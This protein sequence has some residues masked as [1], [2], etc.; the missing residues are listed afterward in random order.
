MF[1]RIYV[2]AETDQRLRMLK[3]RTRLAPNILCRIG[4]CLSISEPGVPDGDL[5]GTTQAREF[6]RYTLTGA[7]DELFFAL[8]RE[9]LTEDGLPKDLAEEQFRAHVSRG[10]LLLTQRMKT[11][12]D[13]GGLIEEANNESSRHPEA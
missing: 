10:V 13:L 4:F 3:A 2:S 5:F 7:W 11:I 6:N 8:L 1:N 12:G 9:R